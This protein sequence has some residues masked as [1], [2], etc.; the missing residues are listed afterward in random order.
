MALVQDDNMVYAFAS[1]AANEPIDVG[2]LP[3]AP[4]SDDVCD[5][6]M[7]HPMPKRAAVDQ[8]PIAQAPV[9][10]RGERSAVY[11]NESDGLT[12]NNFRWTIMDP[13]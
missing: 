13:R 11:Q 3:R 2:I 8:V 7:A 1:D 4:G 9:G 6:H 5:P 12:V 10:V